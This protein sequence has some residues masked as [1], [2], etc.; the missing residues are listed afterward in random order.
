MAE[1]APGGPTTHQRWQPNALGT[2]HETGFAGGA[3]G[4]VE[5]G[6]DRARTFIR[7]LGPLGGERLLHR[8]DI[9][10]FGFGAARRRLSVSVPGHSREGSFSARRVLPEG[11]SRTSG[12]HPSA[13]NAV[14]PRL[15]RIP[16]R[17]RRNS[18]PTWRLPERAGAPEQT[19]PPFF[20][21][22]RLI[23]SFDRLRWFFSRVR[24]R[25]AS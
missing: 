21:L 15:H 5:P 9:S 22:C 13:E 11:D 16:R 7:V 20:D 4:P 1:T 8:G 10:H 14:S 3:G 19:S 24:T 12:K 23:R 25:P 17:D 6:N 18:R 2:G